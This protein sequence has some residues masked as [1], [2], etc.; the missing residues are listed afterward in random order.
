MATQI[1]V[2]LPVKNLKKSMTFFEALG[3]KFQPEFTDETAACLVLSDDI[4]AMLLTESRFRDF[5]KK[6]IADARQ[7]TEAILALGVESRQKV[8][9]IADKALA[10]G[11]EP[12]NA[13]MDHGFMYSRSFQDPDGHLWEVLHMEPSAVPR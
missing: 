13:P 10:A 12:A 7:T 5:T 8:D 3:Y 9:E 11:G 4:Y 6:A 1:F 2:N